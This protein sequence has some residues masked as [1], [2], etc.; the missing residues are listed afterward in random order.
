MPPRRDVKPARLDSM[1]EW[2]EDALKALPELESRAMFGGLGIYSGGTMFAILHG[3]RVYLKTNHQTR[4]AFVQR[5]SEPFRPRKGAV[6]SSY[7]ELPAEI[8]DD[9]AELLAW[10]QR[11]VLVARASAA[12]SSGARA[13]VPPEDILEGHSGEIRALAEKLRVLVRAAAPD[14]TEAGYRGW[15]LIG[16]RSPHYFCFIAPQSDHVRLGFEHGHRLA[17]P[18][19]LLEPMGKQVRFVRLLPGK[20][21]PSAALR[22]LVCAALTTR[23]E[24]RAT[25]ARG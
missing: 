15:K 21:I 16:Y 12:T 14:A 10:A 25:R 9:E 4:V 23:P 22:R 13:A 5:G 2:L 7:H 3:G 20:R 17:D 11:A 8:V 24:R 19:E 1:R 18:D 6:L